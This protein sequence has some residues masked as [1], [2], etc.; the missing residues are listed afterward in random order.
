[1][2]H[3]IQEMNKIQNPTKKYFLSDLV[4]KLVILLVCVKILQKSAYK[5]DWKK[6]WLTDLTLAQTSKV[7]YIVSL[8]AY[9]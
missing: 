6:K 1:M 3:P 7:C 4:T 5:Y 8:Y 9:F 2:E